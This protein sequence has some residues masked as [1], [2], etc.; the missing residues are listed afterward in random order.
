MGLT[1]L[2]LFLLFLLFL[3]L[4]LSS[5]A[6]EQNWMPESDQTN[7]NTKASPGRRFFDFAVNKSNLQTSDAT[8]GNLALDHYQSASLNSSTH[9]ILSGRLDL[10]TTAGEDLNK[11]N[12]SLALREAY[13]TIN[14]DT[15]NLDLG[16][17][18]IRDGVAI[19]YNPSDVFRVG[20]L[21]TR[22][23]EDPSRLRDSRLG[24]LAA[25]ARYSNDYGHFASLFAPAIHSDDSTHWYDPQLKAVNGSQ[26][27]YYLKYTPPRWN[28]FYA[29]LIWRHG[30]EKDTTI[31]INLSRNLG[32]QWMSYLEWVKVRPD[33]SLANTQSTRRSQNTYQQLALGASY[34]TEHRQTVTIEYQFNGAGLRTQEWRGDWQHADAQTLIDTFITSAQRQDPLGRHNMM[35]LLQWD[36][37]I[38]PD[39]DLTCLYRTNVI[40]K[41]RMQWCEW[42]YKQASQEWSLNLTHTSGRPRSEFGS[43]PM[44]LVVGAKLRLFY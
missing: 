32:Q 33:H 29:N 7:E 21:T 24:L 35:A 36:Q 5:A 40:D 20:S 13:F 30:R 19:G 6:Q 22:R 37:F 3:L 43:A 9:W 16:R 12:L 27:Q 41:S 1:L 34:S 39:D 25:Q 31:G 42:R 23:S 8:R 15:L 14:F 10:D 26:A 38:T 11:R 4:P 44:S 2:P 28:D 17:I 18:T